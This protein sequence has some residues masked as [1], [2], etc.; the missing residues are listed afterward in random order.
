M[1]YLEIP[2]DRPIN[3]KISW[4]EN[5]LDRYKNT[6]LA[7]KKIKKLLGEF[8]AAS[9]VSLKEM[10]EIGI[11]DECRKCEEEEGGTCCGAGIENR[12]SGSLILINLLLGV[13]LPREA[14]DTK[15]CFFLGSRGCSL[16]ARHVIC[17]NYI[18]RKITGS[19]PD[20]MI[21]RLREKEGLELDIL[22]I[23]NEHIKALLR[24]L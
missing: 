11:V 22:F 12:Y 1:A 24:R 2:V 21:N 7:D 23:L 8:L 6:F 10:V 16:R 5:C 18:C 13:K 19:I 17:V 4:A 3:E 15:S 14:P 9:S 20:H